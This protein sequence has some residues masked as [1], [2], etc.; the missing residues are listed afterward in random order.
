MIITN[1]QNL[2]QTLVN[3]INSHEH[4]SDADIS[5]S[6]L[7][8]SPR[9]FWLGIRHN[10][11]IEQDVS[12]MIWA[13]FGTA[14]HGI[15]EMGESKNS[16]AEEYFSKVQVGNFSVSGTAD[17]YEDGI[18]Y[19]WKTV[20][21]WSLI[22]LDDAK[23][24]EYI[25]QLNAYAYFFRRANMKVKGL[26][27]VMIMRD[28]QKSKADFD[29]KYPSSQVKVLDIPLFTQEQTE[30][31]L[32]TR[33]DYLMSFKDVPDDELP[34]CTRVYRWPKP[35]KWALMKTGRKSAVKLFDKKEEAE[36]QVTDEKYYIEERKGDEWKRCE[37]CSAWKFCNQTKYVETPIR[38][39]PELKCSMSFDKFMEVVNG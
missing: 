14:V 32:K 9:A 36:S 10:A 22:F 15:A 19:D 16:L 38:E 17:L 24:A 34:L 31:Y 6:Q 21:V 37:Y 35:S 18:I 26:K 28:W 30:Q 2:P 7:L 13:L 1:R 29:C 11:E 39:N 33:I 8:K 23:L 4:K 25:S 12:S 20:A 27:I 5:A 3:A